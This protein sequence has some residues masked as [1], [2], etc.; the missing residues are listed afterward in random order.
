MFSSEE[1]ILRHLYS[2]INVRWLRVGCGA[3]ASELTDSTRSISS[4][5]DLQGCRGESASPPVLGS[6]RE[7]CSGALKWEGWE[8]F[9]EKKLLRT[10]WRAVTGRS[11]RPHVRG[12]EGTVESVWGPELGSVAVGES[13]LSRAWS[14]DTPAHGLASDRHARQAE[15][16]EVT[17]STELAGPQDRSS[18]VQVPA[19]DSRATSAPALFNRYR[20]NC[21]FVL[22][23]SGED[24][25]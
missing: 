22:C 10:V 16:A 5:P 19:G 18:Q 12:R 14:A 23:N 8:H 6:S 2:S 11:R 1:S 3:G 13:G 17:F 4:E 7:R 21:L 20:W 9:S 24:Y 15:S 25:K